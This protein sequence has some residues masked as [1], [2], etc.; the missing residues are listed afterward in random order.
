MLVLGLGLGLKAK[1][2]GLGLAIGRP[3]PWSWDSGLGLG[4]RGLALAKNSRPKS[5]RTA[6]FTFNFRRLERIILDDPRFLL[7]YSGQ[8]SQ[9][10]GD[11]S[12]SWSSNLSLE[13]RHNE[14]SNIRW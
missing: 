9:M 7:T 11:L 14:L 2:C 10:I 3:W 1:F 8:L 12:V 4:L 5:W 6:K 13:P